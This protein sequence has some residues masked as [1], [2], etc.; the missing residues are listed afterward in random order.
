MGTGARLGAGA[1]LCGGLDMCGNYFFGDNEILGGG[2]GAE[3]DAIEIDLAQVL[4]SVPPVLLASVDVDEAPLGQNL[5]P[6]QLGASSSSLLA[7]AAEWRRLNGTLPH[8]GCQGHTA[9]YVAWVGGPAESAASP[10][11]AASSARRLPGTGA[12]SGSDRVGWLHSAMPHRGRRHTFISP[13]PR[14]PAAASA[15]PLPAPLGGAGA[16]RGWLNGTLP[17]RGR[18]HMSRATRGARQQ[19]GRDER[20]TRRTAASEARRRCEAE[21]TV[22]TEAEQRHRQRR[23]RTWRGRQHRQWRRRRAWGRREC[24]H[25]PRLWR[26]PARPADGP[27]PAWCPHKR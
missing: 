12:G 8:W 14:L 11:P 10:T 19:R 23:W 4:G 15:G 16:G 17:H 18:R 26:W 7:T 24:R 13:P 20:D 6:R 25:G 21:A 9:R 27:S 2:G 1:V 22:S 3:Y 5:R